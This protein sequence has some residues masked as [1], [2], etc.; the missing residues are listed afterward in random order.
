MGVAGPALVAFGG[1]GFTGLVMFACGEN[2]TVN[3]AS[4]D[5]AIDGQGQI[6]DD[7]SIKNE[8]P[9]DAS[10]SDDGNANNAPADATPGGPF[11]CTPRH[12]DDLFCTMFNGPQPETGWNQRIVSGGPA[13]DASPLV[14]DPTSFTSAPTSLLSTAAS[15]AISTLVTQIQ[16][17][18]SMPEG[19][20]FSLDF[21][22]RLG[23]YAVAQGARARLMTINFKDVPTRVVRLQAV[24]EGAALRLSLRDLVDTERAQ[25]PLVESGSQWTH[26]RFEGRRDFTVDGGGEPV[27]R[28]TAI[29]NYD[30][31]AAKFVHV[32]TDAASTLDPFDVELGV[33]KG[34]INDSR[35]V[36]I[37]YDNVRIR[38][39][40]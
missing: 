26:I 32:A 16:Q 37:Q 10:S 3:P 4:S 15:G 23:P 35:F 17:D 27:W 21:D 38:R 9:D 2:L 36:N 40:R 1:L 12:A 22:F 39:L 31:A 33:D 7:G 34:G 6:G 18:P 24:V 11:S 14:L 8:Q 19:G 20:P 28:V 29:I 5:A 25:L 30:T 13:G